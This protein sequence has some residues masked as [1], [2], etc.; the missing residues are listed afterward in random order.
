MA[1]SLREATRG[2]LRSM[3]DS[4]YLS[5]LQ[6][7]RPSHGPHV[8]RKR[9]AVIRSFEY[10]GLIQSREVGVLLYILLANIQTSKMPN[11]AMQGMAR[12]VAMAGVRWERASN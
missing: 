11:K 6:V 4:L 10:S 9:V 3:V 12:E 5:C 8:S 2:R 1:Q 7:R